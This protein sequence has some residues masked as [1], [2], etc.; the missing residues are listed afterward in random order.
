ME[1]QIYILERSSDE[2]KVVFRYIVNP[3]KAVSGVF[4]KTY[5]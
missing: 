4:Q 1:A 3:R 2:T 5:V